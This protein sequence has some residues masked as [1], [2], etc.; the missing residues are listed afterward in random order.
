MTVEWNKVTWYSKVLA[1]VLFVATFTLAFYFGQEFEKLK[2]MSVEESLKVYGVPGEVTLAVNESAKFGDLVITLNSVQNDSRCPVDVQCIQAGSVN[3][4]ITISIFEKTI[5]K[6]MSSN[7]V[8]QEYGKYKVS[9]AGVEPQ[10][11]S[12]KKIDQKDYRISFVV[13]E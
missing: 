6:N 13:T 12:T 9:I 10:A 1:M 3:A 8:P 5:S 2:L 11:Y 4:Y 7:E